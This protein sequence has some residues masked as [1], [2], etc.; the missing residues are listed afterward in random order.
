MAVRGVFASHSSIVGDRVNTLSGRVLKK[1]WGGSA[2]LLALSAGMKEDKVSDTSWSWIED[3]HIS[4]NGNVGAGGATDSATTLTVV[5][6]GIWTPNSVLMVE[7]T[8][9]HM[10]ILTVPSNTSITVRRG[11]QGTTPTTIPASGSL[12]LLGTAF[13]EGGGKPTPVMQ[14]GDSF[15][16]F[17]QIFK[18]GWAITGTAKAVQYLTGNK[19]AESREQ[20]TQYHAE[21]I[22]RSFLF[23]RKSV[24]TLN[25]KELR[26]THGLVP[27]IE[28]FGGTVESAAYGSVTGAMS[29][30][31][32]QD[33]M[34][35][36]FQKNAKGLPNERVAFGSIQI[37]NLLQKMVRKDTQ[38]EVTVKDSEFGFDV[39]TLSFVGNRLK[40]LT[41]PLMSENSLWSKMLIVFHPGLIRKRKLRETWTEEFG[42]QRSNNQGIDA[43]EG[44]IGDEM[45]LEVKGAELSG[46]MK[47]IQTSV[48]ST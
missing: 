13:E 10:L 36:I 24:S 5:D 29:T 1:G 20:A 14:G 18:N 41:H 35:P 9:E 3:S 43:E 38:Y 48:A 17:V 31:G 8:G 7:A 22:E 12:Q 21:D 2:P 45:G 25:N 37:L 33:F 47:N 30:D 42:P 23:G 27:Q 15:T 44:Y 28:D 40:I 46:I 34:M 19:L 39:T 26:T 32:I 11:F 4:G 6:A 16:N